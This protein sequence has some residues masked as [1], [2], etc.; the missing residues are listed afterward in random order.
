MGGK[1]CNLIQCNLPKTYQN[2]FQ[3]HIDGSS[4]KETKY[5]NIFIEAPACKRIQYGGYVIY[6]ISN[7]KN[8]SF[9]RMQSI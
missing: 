4:R 8:G 7:E 6:E 5:L 2:R 9:C 1:N 3:I